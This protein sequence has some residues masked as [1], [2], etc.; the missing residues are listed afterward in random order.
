MKTL[1]CYK[2]V[3][4]L[5]YI[6]RSLT[7]RGNVKTLKYLKKIVPKLKIKYFKSGEKFYDWTIPKEWNVKNAYIQTKSGKTHA[8]IIN[9]RASYG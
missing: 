3:K 5:F 4:D 7:G 2:I 8:W 6:N 9:G 1:N